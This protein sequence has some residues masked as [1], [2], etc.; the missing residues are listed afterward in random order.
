[1]VVMNIES[2]LTGRKTQDVMNEA[3]TIA[4]SISLVWTKGVEVVLL[5]CLND[6]SL[7]PRNIKGNTGPDLL[8]RWLTHYKIGLEQRASKRASEMPGTIPDP[9]VDEIISTRLSHLGNEEIRRIRFAHR[10]SMSGE[11]TL[12]LLLED[13]LAAELLPYGWHCCWGATVRSVDFCKEGGSLLQIKNRSNSENSSSN[14]VR[15]GTEIK[16]WYRIV[17]TTGA[18]KWNELNKLIGCNLSEDSF[19]HFV[20]QTVSTNPSL[21]PVE[22][23][24]PWLHAKGA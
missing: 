14:R 24:N 19:R 7:W 18:Y 3:K 21:V 20:K 4:T 8:K 15:E 10:L 2:Y 22:P 11:N 17:A 5:V 12:G 13:Y 23:D 6:P 9:T 16:A 1:M